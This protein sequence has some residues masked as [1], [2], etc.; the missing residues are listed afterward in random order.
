MVSCLVACGRYEDAESEWFRVLESLKAIEFGSKKS[1]KSD[2]RFVPDVKSDRRFVPDDMTP[3]E[4]Y[5]LHLPIVQY[6]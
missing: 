4:Q 5:I 1:V 3:E 6:F 2:R